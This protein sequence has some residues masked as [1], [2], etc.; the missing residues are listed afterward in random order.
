[1]NP[2]TNFSFFGIK[3]KKCVKVSKS[4]ITELKII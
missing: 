2:N 3:N 4:K 1:M